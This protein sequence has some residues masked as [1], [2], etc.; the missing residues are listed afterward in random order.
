M[1]WRSS[2][3]SQQ[4]TVRRLVSKCEKYAEASYRLP[5]KAT[6]LPPPPPDWIFVKSEDEYSQLQ[7]E[8]VLLREMLKMP[9]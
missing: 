9:A 1:M 3:N 7:R 6:A 5:P 8:L 2:C 4:K